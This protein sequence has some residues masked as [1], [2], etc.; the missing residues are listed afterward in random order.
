MSQP[1]LSPNESPRYRT[2]ASA[3]SWFK[4]AESTIASWCD[5]GLITT[6]RHG[7]RVYVD[8]IEI[9]DS[10][11]LHGR[12]VMRDGRGRSK[13]LPPTAIIRGPQSLR[14]QNRA[15]ASSDEATS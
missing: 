12:R 2:R 10:L 6:Y 14:E 9:S 1:A 8:L 4:V 15:P 3:A 5:R 7:G 13:P 11:K